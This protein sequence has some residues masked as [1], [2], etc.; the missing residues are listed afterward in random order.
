[1]VL[2]TRSPSAQNQD[3]CTHERAGD[4]ANFDLSQVSHPES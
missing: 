3:D 2:C 1:V 4:S